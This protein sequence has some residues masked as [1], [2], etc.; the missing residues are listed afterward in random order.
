MESQQSI[1]SIQTRFSAWLADELRPE[2]LMK[3]LATGFMLYL[4]EIIMIL[5]LS[6]DLLRVARGPAPL[7]AG[8]HHDRG[9]SVAH[10]GL[11]A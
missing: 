10:G 1:P 3:G 8:F 2:R 9:C 6:P 11:P 7:W 5:V 4:P